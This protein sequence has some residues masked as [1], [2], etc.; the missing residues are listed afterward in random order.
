M[1]ECD[2]FLFVLHINSVWKVFKFINLDMREMPMNVVYLAQHH[3]AH[4][5]RCREIRT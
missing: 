3:K 5:L 2:F 1:L 4:C